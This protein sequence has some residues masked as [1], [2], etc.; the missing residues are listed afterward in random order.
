KA[1]DGFRYCFK[2]HREITHM[3][4][5]RLTAL[6]SLHFMLKRLGPLAAAGKMGPLLIQLP[7]NLKRDDERLVTFLD[8]LPTT[9]EG[10][11]SLPRPLEW[12]VEFRHASWNEP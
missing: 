3:A 2:L 5:L 4:R 7:P 8:N 6:D 10:V 9:I 12:A 1:E 11:A